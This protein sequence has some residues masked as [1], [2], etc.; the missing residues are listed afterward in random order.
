MIRAL[1][2][3]SYLVF[4]AESYLRAPMKAAAIIGM[5][6]GLRVKRPADTQRKPLR[7]SP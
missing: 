6:L 3:G 5:R 7:G 4:C 2:E 1:W